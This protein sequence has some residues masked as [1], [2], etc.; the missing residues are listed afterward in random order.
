VSFRKEKEM[1]KRF[2]AVGVL[3]LV[4]LTLGA[5]SPAS[6]G[7][8]RSTRP[9]L[10]VIDTTL[11]FTEVDVDNSD[12]LSIGDQFVEHN[13]LKNRSQTKQLGTLDAICTFVDTSDAAATVHCVG[14]AELADG[15][16]EIAGLLHFAD[17]SSTIAITGGT[18]GYDKV[19]G[20]V[21]LRAISDTDVL[22]RFDLE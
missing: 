8:Q 20:Q 5:V 15:S 6:G 12:G 18:G 10:V 13:I 4:A 17:A 9:D 16:I 2:A 14:T 19:K 11:L 21:V 7:D 22:I 1:R 3:V